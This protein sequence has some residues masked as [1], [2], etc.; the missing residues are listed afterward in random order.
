MW[1]Y[2]PTL[3][4]SIATEMMLKTDAVTKRQNLH[5]LFFVRTVV[6][7]RI[8]HVQYIR[9]TTPPQGIKHLAFSNMCTHHPKENQPPAG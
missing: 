4:E 6:V 3:S 8:R 7:E 5:G 1:R 2:V 9:S